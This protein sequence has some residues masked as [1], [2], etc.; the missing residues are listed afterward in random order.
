MPFDETIDVTYLQLHLRL[1]GPAVGFSLEIEIEEALLQVSPVVGVKMRPVL[2]TMTFEPFLLRRSADKTFEISAGMQTLTA[3][4]GR[5]QQRDGDLVP[6]RRARLVVFIVERM[7]RISS[8][9]LERFR[10]SC[11]SDIVSSPHTSAPVTMLRGPRS[12]SPYCTVF[13]CMSYQLAQNVDRM[14]P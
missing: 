4:V 13:T 8:P 2:E 6:V 12:P 1:V 5:R 11:S 3:P 10:V 14:P 7:P 9:K